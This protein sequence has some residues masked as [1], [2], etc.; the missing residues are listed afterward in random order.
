MFLLKLAV[1][2]IMLMGLAL[3]LV[4]RFPGTVIIL[5]GAALYGALTS[6]DTATPW[7]WTA[8]LLL[9]A[10]AEVGGRLLRVVL[11]RKFNLSREFCA[12]STIGNVGGILAA[13][14]LLGPVI[15]LI[16]WELIAGKT[17]QPRWDTV[18]KILLRLT[19]VAALRFCCGFA[20][21]LLTWLYLFR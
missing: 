4:P 20:M 8:M 21:M 17:L 7:L 2:L 3:T 5:L 18:A 14:A 13:E 9:V 1:T 15:G 19:A 10:S 6:F 12:N 11:T 16:V